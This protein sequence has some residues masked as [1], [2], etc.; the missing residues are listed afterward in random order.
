MAFLEIA[1]QRHPVPPGEAVIGS[2]PSAA[3]TLEGAGVAPCHALLQTGADGQ[4][5]LRRS[6]ENVEIL[7]NGMRLGP[8]P[9]PLL[10]GDRIEIA[11]H[12]LLFVD[13]RRTESTQYIE[14]I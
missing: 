9:T 5:V 3:V 13:E 12:E 14:G 7:I 1:G 10:H 11:G 8:Q 6:D 2:D 4:V